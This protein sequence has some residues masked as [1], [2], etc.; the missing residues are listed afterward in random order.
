MTEQNKLHLV[1]VVFFLIEDIP[2][3][4]NRRNKTVYYVK[5]QQCYII[6]VPEE[7]WPEYGLKKDRNMLP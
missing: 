3:C 4:F 6:I 7:R 5:T 1:R 2:L